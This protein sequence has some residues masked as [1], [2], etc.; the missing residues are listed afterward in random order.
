MR[1]Q[2]QLC[3][4]PSGGLGNRMRAVA[5]AYLLHSQ[6]GVEVRVKWF[7]D[8]ALDAPFAALPAFR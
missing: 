3:F 4:I 1:N 7:R 2:R 8:W 5:S 6:T